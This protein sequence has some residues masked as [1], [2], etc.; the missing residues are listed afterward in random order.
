M[1]KWFGLRD[2]A[3]FPKL[4]KSTDPK[5]MGKGAGRPNTASPDDGPQRTFIKRASASTYA[6]PKDPGS[7]PSHQGT[8]PKDSKIEVLSWTWGAGLRRPVVLIPACLAVGACVAIGFLLFRDGGSD[9]GTTG[10]GV[11]TGTGFGN[12]SDPGQVPPPVTVAGATAPSVANGSAPSMATESTA[13]ATPQT[14]GSAGDTPTVPPSVGVTIAPPRADVDPRFESC[15]QAMKEGFGP[16]M[17]G[18]D[19][20]FDW[21]PDENRDGVVCDK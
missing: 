13:T 18:K 6:A 15:E 14:A 9:E 7:E 3:R 10:S 8:S 16:Y 12:G 21:Y 11:P 17:K 5:A 20:E 19:P 1:F 2:A 4:G